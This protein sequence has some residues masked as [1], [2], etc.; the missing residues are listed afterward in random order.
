MVKGETRVRRALLGA[1]LSGFAAVAQASP[2]N[3]IRLGG[4]SGRL[5]PYLEF[6][7]RYDSNVAY[8]EQGKAMSGFILHYRPGLTLESPGDSAAVD[9]KANLD[10][11][12]YLGKNS[13][14]SRLY[15]EALL[16]VGLNRKGSIGLELTD[17]FRRADTTQVLSFGGAVVENSNLLQ[18]GVP[19]RPGGG[20]FVATVSG[21]WNLETFEPFNKGTLCAE[22]IPQCN[23]SQLSQLGYSDVSGGLELRWRF[24]PRTAAVLQG[25]YWKRLPVNAELSG[26]PRGWRTWAGM[27]GLV[28][29]HLASTLKGGW[30][31]VSDAPGTISSWLANAEAEWIPVETASLKLGYIHDVGVDPGMAGFTSHRGYLAAHALLA[32]Q[33][34]VQLGGGYEHRDYPDS[35]GFTANLLTAEPS[36]DIELARW[37]RVG[38][39]VA[40]TK[41]TSK[42]PPGTPNLPG[43]NFNKT[44]AY[45]RL[46]GTY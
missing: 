2:G 9:L 41:R 29:A 46:R 8:D 32:S 16:G 33:Y 14:L 39:G 28:T 1:L 12:Q 34:I 4:S 35:A 37:L 6:E 24:L 40:Y 36:V 10:W 5:H 18:V 44:E 11:A 42:L 31:S 17:S 45:V 22:P 43:F 27:A 21:G 20:A 19:W 15:G 3:G 26:K 38:T 23:Q 7:T 30:G 25:E 13:D